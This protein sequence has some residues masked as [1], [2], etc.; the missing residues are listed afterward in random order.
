MKKKI[1]TGLSMLILICIIF[2]Y[3]VSAADENVIEKARNGIVE[4]QSGFIHSNGK[5]YQMKYGSGFL[6]SNEQGA[7]YI[8]TC[9]TIAENSNDE[10]KEYCE[11]RNLA[12]DSSQYSNIVRII[13]KGDVAVEA[14]IKAKSAYDNYCILETDGVLSEKTALKLGDT[15]V[16]KANATV[17]ALGFPEK[18]KNIEFSVNDVEVFYGVLESIKTE[19]E[20][21]KQIKHT[22][23]IHE[24]STGGPLLDEDGYVIGV[25]IGQSAYS[26]AINGIA[27]LLDNYGIYYGSRWLDEKYANLQTLYDECQIIVQEGKYKYESIQALEAVMQDARQVLEEKSPNKKMLEE[28]FSNLTTAKESMIPKTSKVTIFIFILGGCIIVLVIWLIVLL[29]L[30]H[31]DAKKECDAQNRKM[32]ENSM[33]SQKFSEMFQSSNQ[34]YEKPSICQTTPV[35][36]PM[37]L[38]RVSNREAIPIIKDEFYLGSNP[39]MTDYCIANNKTI[40]RRH[41]MIGFDEKGYYFSDLNSSNGSA[42]NGRKAAGWQRMMIQA[43]DE[44]MLANERFLVR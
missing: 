21:I 34:L 16:L 9:E 29:V 33:A 36:T 35:K 17:Y 24:G 26:V 43:G 10:I 5:F 31:K 1:F 19:D 18:P 42:V 8:L 28:A 25:N 6:L 44:I 27:E 11:T 38:Y 20:K 37:T 7:T 23:N 22:M 13:V 3:R 15:S 30:N 12:T 14:S 2:T 41:A 4:I 32:F 40:S 39:D